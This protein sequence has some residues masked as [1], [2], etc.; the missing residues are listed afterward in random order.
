MKNPKRDD[1]PTKEEILASIKRGFQQ[2]LRGEGRP[3]LEVLDELDR[4]VEDEA[5]PFH[6][7]NLKD[8][9]DE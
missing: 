3:A 5:R 2:A 9:S 6:N 4:E 7:G 8:S 1:E